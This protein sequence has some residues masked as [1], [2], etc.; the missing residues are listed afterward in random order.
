ML[1]L[2]KKNYKR[3]IIAGL[4][5]IFVF[6]M[7]GCKNKTE[8]LVAQVDGE[9]ITEEE[10]ES[11]YQVF[12]RIYEKQLGEDALTQVDANGKT[13]GETLKVNIIEKLIME[14]L[15]AKET[16]NMDIVVTDKE[17]QEQ[18]EQ[19]IATME[20]QEKFDEFL[21]SNELSEELFKES[22][23]KELLV[24]K[25]KEAFVAGVNISDKEA[26][27]YFKANKED[28]VVIK[29]SHILVATEEEGKKVLEKLKAGEEFATVAL[30]ESMDSTSAIRGGSLGYFTKGTII[31]A[32]FEDVAFSL[33]QGETSG[34]VKTELGYHIIYIEDRKD[35]FEVLKAEIIN[36]LKEGK[37]LDKIQGLR[38]KAKVKIFQSTNTDK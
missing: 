37:Y 22:L 29:A 28:L 11:D 12:K 1:K 16:K 14:K 2:Y 3:L 24:N 7:S 34:L 10:F 38:D 27:E 18:M 15:V 4:L 17:V 5:L 26:Q 8:G 31:A 36:V 9:E 25:H 20:G 23:R 33:K 6:T 32:E 13:L 19:Y 21:K 30:T 35:T